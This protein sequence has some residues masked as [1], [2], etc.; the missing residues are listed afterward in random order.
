[1]SEKEWQI[2][3]ETLSQQRNDAMNK[4]AMLQAQVA[5][6]N[7]AVNNLTEQLTK[8]KENTHDSSIVAV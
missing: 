5:T 7:E 4:V 1:M 6:L 3:C 2:V 8:V